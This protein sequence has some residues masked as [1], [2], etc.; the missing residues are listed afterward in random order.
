MK[1]V[2]KMF[3]LAVVFCVLTCFTMSVNAIS[4]QDSDIWVSDGYQ[5]KFDW[6]SQPYS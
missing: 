1:L 5:A 2:K 4:I 3:T 6:S